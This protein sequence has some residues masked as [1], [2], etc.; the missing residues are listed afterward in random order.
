MSM[1]AVS[2]CEDPATAAYW[3]SSD[4]D[5]GAGFPD[6]VQDSVL[7]VPGYGKHSC[8]RYTFNSTSEQQ[9]C[10]SFTQRAS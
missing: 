2:E 1:T 3:S 7:A 9:T 10:D 6:Y 8:Q 4:G 5:S